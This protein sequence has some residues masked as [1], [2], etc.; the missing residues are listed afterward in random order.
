MVGFWGRIALGGAA[1]RYKELKD[2]NQ[3]YMQEKSDILQTALWKA[4][5]KRKS[6]VE[7]E[8]SKL[9]DSVVWPPD[10][11]PSYSCSIGI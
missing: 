7:A 9:K 3:E 4:S 5:A 6:L 1:E 10:E 2:E 8:K 11:P